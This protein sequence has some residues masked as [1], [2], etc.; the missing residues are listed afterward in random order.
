MLTPT[1]PPSA[2]TFS[3]TT[4]GDSTRTQHFLVAPRAMVDTP[5]DA[6]AL[7]EENYLNYNLEYENYP[8]YHSDDS[9]CCPSLAESEEFSV[10]QHRRRECNTGTHPAFISTFPSCTSGATSTKSHPN[11]HTARHYQPRQEEDEE[12]HPLL[13][14]PLY[15]LP[16]LG[17]LTPEDLNDDF[18]RVYNTL[19]KTPEEYLLY[20][21]TTQYDYVSRRG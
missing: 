17:Y 3:C 18:S 11:L 19:A 10:N 12:Y 8:S 2:K 16:M 14:E 13:Q 20:E 21:Y 5:G 1:P 9:D 4:S 6:P 15:D 7:Q